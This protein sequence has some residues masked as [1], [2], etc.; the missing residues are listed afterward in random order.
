[1]R[2]ARLGSTSGAAQAGAVPLS[3]RDPFAYALIR[4][5]P[6]VE[7]GECVNVGAVLFCRARRF[8]EA[9]LEL[10]RGRLVA[11]AP[12]L[13]LPAVQRQIDLIRLVCRGDPAAGPIGTLPQAERFGWVVAP[14]ST[15]VQPGPVH[16]GL[17]LDPSEELDRLFRTM[18]QVR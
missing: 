6:R 1:V 7:R 16:A 14:A 12:D 2:G 10:D 15:V 9:R 3:R 4:V 13:D 5:V 17:C 8:L 11:M 18:V